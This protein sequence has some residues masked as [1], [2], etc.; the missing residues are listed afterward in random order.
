[1]KGFSLI[2]SNILKLLPLLKIKKQ[3]YLKNSLKDGKLLKNILFSKF[4]NLFAFFFHLQNI[5]SIY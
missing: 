4:K 1:M 2:V 5:P 3:I